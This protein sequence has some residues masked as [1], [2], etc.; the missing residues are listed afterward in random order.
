MGVQGNTQS[1]KPSKT[2]VAESAAGTR[3]SPGPYIGLVKNNMDASRS[4]SVSVW[5]PELGG[6]EEDEAS[7]RNV[8]YC[9]PFFGAT[10]PGKRDRKSVLFR[11]IWMLVDQVVLVFGFQN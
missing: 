3:I 7:W 8:R 10:P 11:S 1:T 5:I 6:K 9:S 2:A 4:G